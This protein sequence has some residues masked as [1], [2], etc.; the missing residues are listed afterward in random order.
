M[1]N[2]WLEIPLLGFLLIAPL[3]TIWKRLGLKKA[4]G[5]PF[6]FG[7][8]AISLVALLVLVPVI[9]ILAIENVLPKDALVSLLGTIVGYTMSGLTKD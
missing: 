9:C 7:Q 8:R 6:G 3:Y 1:Q 5:N 4:D 2:K